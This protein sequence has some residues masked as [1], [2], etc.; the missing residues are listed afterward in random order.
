MGV[1]VGPMLG[2]AVG[3]FLAEIYD[4]RAAFYVVAVMGTLPPPAAL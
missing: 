2:P 3:G 1:V 4:W